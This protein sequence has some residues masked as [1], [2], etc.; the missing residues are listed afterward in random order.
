MY[1]K[2]STDP[3]FEIRERNS[4]PLEAERSP[5]DFGK[6][7]IVQLQQR[8]RNLRLFRLLMGSCREIL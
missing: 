7:R 2:A 1:L 6:S 8:G 4:R 5:R 3:L